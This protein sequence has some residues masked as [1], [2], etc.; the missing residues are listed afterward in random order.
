MQRC[1]RFNL[2]VSF[3]VV[4][5]LMLF[6]SCRSVYA[7]SGSS[8]REETKKKVIDA[9]IIKNEG[10]DRDLVK[11]G[12]EQVSALWRDEDGDEI[13]FEAFCTVQ[14]I[15][16]PVQRSA[17]LARC[18]RNFEVIDGSFNEIMRTINE[19]LQLDYGPVSP[20]NYLFSRFSPTSHLNEDL[21][22]SKTSFA[23]LLNFPLCSL[24]EKLKDGP[25]WTREQWAGMRLCSRFERRVPSVIGQK[26]N[27]FYSE[28]EQYIYNYKIDMHSLITAGGETLF[29]EGMRLSSHWGLRDELKGQYRKKD[30]AAKQEMIAKVME[31][32]ICQ[33]IPDAVLKDKEV[34]WD[35]FSNRVFHK[36][37]EVEYIPEKNE[38]YV[39]LKNVF[40]AAQLIDPFVP[41]KP[42]Q[43]ERFFEY[44]MEIPESEVEAHLVDIMKAPE[45]KRAAKLMEK[46]LGRKLKDYDIWYSGFRPDTTAGEN[47]LDELVMKRYPSIQSFQDSLPAILQKLGFTAEKAQFLGARIIVD[48]ARGSGHCNGPK[49]RGDCAH[50]RTPFVSGRMNYESFNTAMHE[51]GHAVEQVFSMYETDHTIL[52]SVPNTAFTEAFAFIFESKDLEVLG[53]EKASKQKEDLNAI[54]TLWSTYEISGVALL[55]M[56][57]WH[58]MYAHPDA[59]DAELKEAVLREARSIWNEYYAPVLG[60]KDSPLLAVYSH[61]IYRDLYIPN[62]P[63][64]YIIMFQIEEHLKRHSLPE[65]MERMCRQGRLTPDLWMKGATGSKISTA[66]MKE[67][68]RR[69]LDNLER[70]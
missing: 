49:R 58:W 60:K 14:Y 8:I 51:L 62:Y 56:N 4:L 37:A 2:T 50:L 17:F 65:E 40:K 11:R 29:P 28:A 44:D 23:I 53:I 36:G 39:H 68:A 19:P 47:S 30:G 61:M 26:V 10:A 6:Y 70:Q 13:G 43:I 59:T 22:T 54:E 9:I 42:R 25:S 27:V 46:R 41:S 52:A 3:L 57:I 20:Y 32:I 5:I 55:S 21:F 18:E 35:P 12:V 24:D 64:G 7:A 38:R 33:E 63:M 66:P 15:A 48:P 16:D 31:R 1:R 67:A 34:Q 69:A 45:V